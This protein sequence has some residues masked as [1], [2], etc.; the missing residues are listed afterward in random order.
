[1]DVPPNL[2]RIVLRSC[3]DGVP[4]VVELARKYLVLVT[5]QNLKHLSSLDVPQS[6]CVVET[7]RK[8][9]GALRVKDCF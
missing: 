5:L 7:G 3:D 1:M 9:F 6:G 2:A 8:D 4:F